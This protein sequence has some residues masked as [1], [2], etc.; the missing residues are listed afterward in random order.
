MGQGDSQVQA[1]LD[2]GADPE[3]R[4]VAMSQ[5]ASRR[6]WDTVKMMP[7][8]AGSAN[9]VRKEPHRASSKDY[10]SKHFT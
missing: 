8:K 7:W 5:K 10:L 1:L 9:N 6:Y 4:W 3:F 2:G